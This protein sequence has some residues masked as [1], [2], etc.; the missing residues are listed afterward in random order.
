ML[1]FKESEA[2]EYSSDVLMGL[3]YLGWDYQE[4]EKDP[5]RTRRLRDLLKQMERTTKATE[6]AG[7]IDMRKLQLKVLKHRNGRKGEVRL[8][9][10]SKYNYFQE[11]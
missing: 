5:D 9:F 1:S 3:Q 4:Q 6:E 8:G 2:I 10:V 7:R 11:E